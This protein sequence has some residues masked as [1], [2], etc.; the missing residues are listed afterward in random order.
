MIFI[1]YLLHF[2]KKINKKNLEILKL[3]GKGITL[4]LQEIEGNK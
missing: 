4:K 3:K 2:I 1:S